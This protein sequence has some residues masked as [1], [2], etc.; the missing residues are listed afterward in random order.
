MR[1]RRRCPS[2][3]SARPSPSRS[4][5]TRCAPRA[6]RSTATSRPIPDAAPVTIAI[7]TCELGRRRRERQLVELE[8]PV[9]ELEHVS[10]VEPARRPERV[11]RRGDGRRASAPRAPARL[12]P[13]ERRAPPRCIRAPARAGPAGRC[14]ASAGRQPPRSARR[15]RG[16]RLRSDRSRGHVIVEPDDAR[17]DA[18]PKHVVGRA[19]KPCQRLD[20]GAVGERPLMARR[21]EHL[22]LLLREPA[23]KPREKRLDPS[24]R[25]ASPQ[26]CRG[27]A[28]REEAPARDRRAPASA[29]RTPRASRPR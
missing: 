2:T 3:V 14:R 16:S 20:V 23:S 1:P 4:A 8:R 7:M 29:R 13:S 27:L 9:L 28:R 6:A 10:L 26:A 21:H 18:D 24:G 11:E 17:A 15:R 25:A 12:W 19:P 5:S 22:P